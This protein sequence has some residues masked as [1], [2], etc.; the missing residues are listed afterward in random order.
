MNRTA[1][2]LIVI[3]I[4]APEL[5]LGESLAKFDEYL[6]SRFA[7]AIRYSL[8]S[9]GLDLRRPNAAELR[10]RQRSRAALRPWPTEGVD[11]LKTQ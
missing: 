2:K 11:G 10:H 6:N 8:H 7:Y 4:L 9:H 5:F 3:G 1:R